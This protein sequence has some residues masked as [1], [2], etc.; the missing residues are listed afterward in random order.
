MLNWYG[1]NVRYDKYSIY[2]YIDKKIMPPRPIVRW[3]GSKRRLLP[4]LMGSVPSNYGRYIEPFVG[5]ACLFLALNPKHAVL[6]D[7]NKSLI[8]SYRVLAYS[9]VKL[10]D[11]LHTSPKTADFYYE[12]RGMNPELLT[13]FERAVRFFYLNRYCFNGVYRTNKKGQFNVPRGTRTGSIPSVE[14]FRNQSTMMKN[15]TL[16]HCDFVECLE[17]ARRNDFIYLDPPYS[18]VDS[19]ASGEY[20]YGAFC[21]D[22]LQR[23]VDSLIKLDASGVKVL[24]SYTNEQFLTK[25]LDGRWKIKPVIARRSMAGFNSSSSTVEEILVSNYSA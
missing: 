17:L 24:L 20:G 12:L 16:K 25:M 8:E 21:Q 10:A 9:P 7:F 22:D 14:E 23:L 4:V 13:R 15:A 11:A 19:V 18:K 3:A 2:M 6:G 1:N 5:S